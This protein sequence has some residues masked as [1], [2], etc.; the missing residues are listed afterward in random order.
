V[1]SHRAIVKEIVVA[2]ALA[3]AFA[4]GGGGGYGGGPTGPSPGVGGPGP[5][6]ATITI[7][8]NSLTPATVTITSGQSITFVNSD[9]RAHDMA[10]DPHPGHTDCPAVNGASIPAGQSRTTNAFTTA[11][12]CGFH[13]HLDET[14]ANLRGSIVVR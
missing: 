5:V 10:S 13:D 14:N 7:G 6:G 8:A 4:C 3:A 12:T 9:S 1:T 2:F 11:R